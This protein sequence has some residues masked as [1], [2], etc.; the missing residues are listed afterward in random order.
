MTSCTSGIIPLH[1]TGNIQGSVHCFS[2]YTKR[3]V[4][5][6][7][8]IVIPMPDIVIYMLNKLADEDKLEDRVTRDPEIRVRNQVIR[9]LTDHDEQLITDTTE[10]NQLDGSETTQPA[11]NILRPTNSRTQPQHVMWTQG[12]RFSFR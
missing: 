11:Q 6:D 8:W 9:L 12:S 1:S 7:S 10:L 5:R 4:V 3:E 2:L